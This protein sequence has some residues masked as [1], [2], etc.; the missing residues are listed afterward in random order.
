MNNVLPLRIVVKKILL[1][2]KIKLMIT[3]LKNI[4]NFTILIKAKL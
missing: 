4:Q 2:T 1:I 3:L